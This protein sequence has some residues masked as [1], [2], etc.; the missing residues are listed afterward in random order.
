MKHTILFLLLT[1]IAP[2]LSAQGVDGYQSLDAE[3]PILFGGT[4]IVYQGDK[5]ALNEKN[6]FVDGR[7]SAAETAKYPFAFNSVNNAMKH[8]TAGTEAEPM[9][10]YLA[11]YVYWVDCP[12]DSVVRKPVSGEIPYGL[13]V[14]CSWL[15]LRGLTMKA[16]NVVLAS[17]RG[18]TQGAVGNFTMFHFEGDG[19]CVENLTM[20]NY[21]NIDLKYPLLP[22]LNRVKRSSAIVQAQLAICDGDKIVA[23]NV[24]FLSRLNSCPLVGGRRVLFDRCYFE[25]TDD[26]LCGTGVYLDC[27]LT[28]FSSKPFYRTQGAGAVFLNCDFDVLTK[29]RQYLTKVGSPITIV[30]SR[31]THHPGTLYVGWTQNPTDDLRSYQYNVLLNGRPLFINADKPWLTVDM[32]DKRILNA[33]RLLYNGKVIYNTYNLLRGED[34]WDPMGVKEVVNAASKVSGVDYRNIPT[35]LR[36]SPAHSEIESG[37]TITKLNAVVNRLGG[38]MQQNE[39]VAWAVTPEHKNLI[40]INKVGNDSCEVNGRNENDATA[41]VVVTAATS[42]GLESAAVITVMPRYLNAPKFTVLPKIVSQEKGRLRVDYAL[43]LEGRADQS[44]IT[45]YRCKDAGGNGAVAVAVSRLNHPERIYRLTPADVG[46]HIM[47]AVSPKHLRCHQGMAETYITHSPVSENSVMKGQEYYTDF[48]NFP[49]AYQPKVISGFWTVDGYKPLDTQ[50]YNWEPDKMNS[51]LYGRGVDGAKGTGLLQAAKGA[52]LLYTPVSG[53]YGDMSVTLNVDPCKTA[54]QGFGSA[55]GQ[56]LD[57]Y[58]KFD[59]KM[60][61]GYAL[62]IIRTTKYDKA[63]DFVLMEYNNGVAKA[64][65]N[66]ITSTCYRAGCTI[67]LSVT[68]NQLAAHAETT[69]KPMELTS[70]EVKPIIDLHA[71]I[72]PNTFGGTGV[73][74]TGSVGASATMLRWMKVMWK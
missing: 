6:F 28:L 69:A 5:I 51:W 3:N 43:S 4:Y 13:K 10:I 12:D 42:S 31:F 57:I 25:C 52:R 18:Q 35:M 20:G 46:Y 7:L 36:I 22:E 71:E 26:A 23:R 34:E 9:T 11:P 74:H 64:I 41:T 55:T 17:N 14:K 39:P 60:L 53:K 1:A 65:S 73:Q 49:T 61:T 72:S 44:L 37:V 40:S 66:P 32:T 38:F 21:C 62:R 70:P 16:E 15:R 56:Y 63:V 59:T 2:F 54:G 19:L 8:L 47:V 45:W 58:I 27:K 67:T 50:A 29:E 68:G 30:D 48:Q 33:Y 24:Q